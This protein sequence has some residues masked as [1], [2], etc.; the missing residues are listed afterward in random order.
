MEFKKTVDVLDYIRTHITN[1]EKLCFMKKRVFMPYSGQQAQIIDKYALLIGIND[2]ELLSDIF[3]FF[4]N[5]TNY[6]TT[7]EWNYKEGDRVVANPELSMIAIFGY[8][9]EEWD[10]E[11]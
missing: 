9:Y 4:E 10:K 3:N 1:D 2:E 8:L 6:L 7:T 11:A 5:E